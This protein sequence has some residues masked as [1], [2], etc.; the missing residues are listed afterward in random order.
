MYVETAKS[1]VRLSAQTALY[2]L[3]SIISKSF[4][5]I[6]PHLA[7]EIYSHRVGLPDGL[8]LVQ[9]TFCISLIPDLVCVVTESGSAFKNGWLDCP[10]SWRRPDLATDFE[11]GRQIQNLAHNVLEKARIDKAIG[12]S[13]EADLIIATPKGRV[14]D[15]LRV[16]TFINL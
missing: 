11:I 13:L 15:A 4:A 8:L 6:L 5:P 9:F 10:S 12:S 3:L 2:H 14:Y 1:P 7:E 16:S